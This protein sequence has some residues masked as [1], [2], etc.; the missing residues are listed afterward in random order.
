MSGGQP[1]DNTFAAMIEAAYAARD[2]WL[3]EEHQ[4]SL[5]LQDAMFDRWERARKLG[6]GEG[7]SIY[8]SAIVYGDV[9]VGERSWIG[10]YVLLDGSGGPLTI[11]AY[12]SI[13]AGTHIY[14]HD[15][16]KWALSGGHSPY[17]KA[18]VSIGDRCYVG[19]QVIIAAGVSIGTCSVISANSLVK[20]DVPP[21]TIVGGT[22][23]RRIGK[24][25]FDNME[26]Q[27]VFDDNVRSGAAAAPV[28]TGIRAY[29]DMVVARIAQDSFGQ[30]AGPIVTLS[31][32][33]AE[34]PGIGVSGSVE[35][36]IARRDG[37][38]ALLH[39]EAFMGL[40]SRDDVDDLFARVLSVVLMNH[41]D[42]PR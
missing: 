21:Q 24:V 1:G 5:P 9:R 29:L 35:V 2:E 23:A 4:R 39:R 41:T 40:K 26:P 7:A 25:V 32:D 15:T 12:C 13:S 19:S 22:P 10:P 42:W 34:A 11:G 3:R 30:R 8:N 17:R 20:D 38:P 18:A 33:T 27:L 6:F 16:V 37:T 36:R 28:A 14:T 31:E